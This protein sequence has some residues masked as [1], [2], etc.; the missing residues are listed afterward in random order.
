MV[1]LSDHGDPKIELSSRMP[2]GSLSGRPEFAAEFL[3]AAT[4]AVGRR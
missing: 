4:P 2:I 1:D 3:G